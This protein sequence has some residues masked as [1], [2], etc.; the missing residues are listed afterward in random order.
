MR[1]PAKLSAVLLGTAA[2]TAIS[3]SPAVA[4][5]NAELLAEIRKL[6]ERLQQ[7]ETQVAKKTGSPPTP[8]KARTGELTPPGICWQADWNRSCERVIDLVLV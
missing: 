1:P 4:Q 5:S 2:I 3:A 7:L 8:L 6:N